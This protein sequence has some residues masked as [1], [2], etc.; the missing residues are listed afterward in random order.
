[1]K[2]SLIGVVA[3]TFALACAGSRP[4][5]VTV[6]GDPANV[7]PLVGRWQG[8]Y[9]S[10]STGRSG[11]IVFTLA[12]AGDAA[13]GDVVMV[14]AGSGRTLEP[15]DRA[16]ANVQTGARS[17]VL[18][19]RVVRVGDGTVTGVL[20]P[21]RD[22]ACD[23]PVQTTFNGRLDGDTITGTFTTTGASTLSQSGTWRVR[24]Q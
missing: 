22:P 19:I 4:A 5:P 7:A 23:C 3:A 9:A 14:D 12:N 1:M 8:D 20:D 13:R 17:Q 15:F 2:A 10:P 18:T 11:S 16:G 24:R 21:Y 6:T